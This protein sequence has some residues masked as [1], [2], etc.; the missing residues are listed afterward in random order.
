MPLTFV[1]RCLPCV[2]IVAG[3][4]APPTSAAQQAPSKSGFV[5]KKGNDTV[6][7]EL[8]TRDGPT[9]TSE[10]Y[11]SNGLRTQYTATL[12]ADGSVK[13]VEM[14]RR[15]RQG[16]GMTLIIAFGDTLVS[17]NATTAAGENEKM[18]FPGRGHRTP[19]L[20]VSFALSEQIVR[21]SRLDVG[22]SAKWTAFRLGAADTVSLTL[23]RFHAD[24]VLFAMPDVQLKV[25]V[26]ATGDVTGGRH[27][28][29]DWVIER[30]K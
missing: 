24:S 26:S 12:G 13:Y 15:G 28:G 22:K 11:Q 1:A 10:V 21:A 4:H 30:R 20:A 25:A 2:A 6:A 8:Y 17:A 29:Q 5:V 19:F 3:L 27:L 23:T 7:V 16:Q 9:L 18:E 14:S